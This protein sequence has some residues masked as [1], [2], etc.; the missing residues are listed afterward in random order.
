[1]I[2]PTAII[3]AKCQLGSGIS[4]GPYTIIHDNVQLGDNCSIG[5][6]CEIGLP[7]PLAEGRPLIIGAGANIRSHS[8]FYEGSKIGGGLATGHRVTVREGTIAGEG[9]QIGTLGDIQGSCVM[10]EHVRFHSNVHI[11][12]HSKIGNFVWI[13]PYVV[14]TNDPHPPS[15]VMSGVVVEDYAAIATMSIILPGLT[16][17]SGA[18]VGAHSSVT[19]NV[20]ADTV[21]AGVPARSICKTSEIILKD[22]SGQPAYPW[23]RHFHRGYPKVEIEKWLEEFGFAASFDLQEDQK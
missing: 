9:F 21:V 1:M 19:R 16:V 13:F 15:N 2:H 7:T 4:V 20:P 10:G 22:G 8:V 6:H 17:G 18:L 5:S 3:S 23:R 11:G 14:L 12:K